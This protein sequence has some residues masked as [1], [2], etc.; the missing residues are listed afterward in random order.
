MVR[1]TSVVS[2][3]LS[4]GILFFEW[5]FGA[6]I[7]FMCAM[8]PLFN[9]PRIVDMGRLVDRVTGHQ[10]LVESALDNRNADGGPVLAQ[11]A[12]AALCVGNA[13]MV[14]RRNGHRNRGRR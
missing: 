3:I 11:R 5:T 1:I 12:R 9:R 7:L 14:S 10:G 4:A 6:S 2:A 8:W 13:S